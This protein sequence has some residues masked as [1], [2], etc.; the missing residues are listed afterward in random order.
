ME[1]T[2]R[3]LLNITRRWN[4]ISHR[5]GR[6]QSVLHSHLSATVVTTR[7]AALELLFLPS[8]LGQSAC[9]PHP[10]FFSAIKASTFHIP[11]LP[12][13][14]FQWVVVTNDKKKLV[15]HK[16]NR[17]KRLISKTCT[18]LVSHSKTKAHDRQPLVPDNPI[19]KDVPHSIFT[20]LKLYYNKTPRLTSDVF[21]TQVLLHLRTKHR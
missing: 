19:N 2:G 8:L 10:T 3:S 12:K 16:P 1:V 21:N 18:D 17:L 7:V 13:K 5:L 4:S 15:M 14:S 11:A 20:N 6:Q 9:S